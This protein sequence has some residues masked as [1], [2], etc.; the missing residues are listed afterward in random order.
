MRRREG[1]SQ[2]GGEGRGEVRWGEVGMIG[3]NGKAGWMDVSEQG[4]SDM[5][6]GILGG[7]GGFE[8]RCKRGRK[9]RE[10]MRTQLMR[11]HP[12]WRRGFF[13]EGG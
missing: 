10:E 4:E 6:F 5:G 12:L 8:G 7:G 2:G 3:V 1:R 9:R 13:L 11:I